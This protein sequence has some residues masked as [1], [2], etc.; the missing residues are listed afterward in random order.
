MQTVLGNRDG[1]HS[2]RRP[3]CVNVSTWSGRVR[4]SAQ[5]TDPRTRKSRNLVFPGLLVRGEPCLAPAATKTT[6]FL[7]QASGDRLSIPVQKSSSAA[8]AEEGEFKV[9][10]IKMFGLAAIAA[11]AAMAF[12]G[13]TSASAE[14][15]QLCKVH[16]VTCGAGDATTS[17]HQVN[18]G[19]GTLLSSIVDVLCL[20]VLAEATPLALGAPQS[21]HTLA[22][23]FTGCGTTSTH[24]NCTVT[25]LELPLANLLKTGLDEGSIEGT[26]GKT[27]LQCSNIPFIGSIDC[28][29]DATG[30]LFEVAANHLTAS[31][32]PVKEIGSKFFCPDKPT[33]DGLLETLVD[34]FVVG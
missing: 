6:R 20:N 22:L 14:S 25:V 15:T 8:I 10:L 4:G 21:V 33:L 12:V 30:L 2:F 1:L 19:V 5:R 13:A 9:R 11:V 27:R 32:T 3:L 31:E 7:D 17:V 23:S 34:T 29:Y 24:N 28:T 26:N 16:T 18:V